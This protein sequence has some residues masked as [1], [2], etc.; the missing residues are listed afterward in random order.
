MA[1]EPREGGGGGNRGRDRDRNNNNS[2]RDEGGADV[3]LAIPVKA[4]AA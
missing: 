4:L 3:C 2:N 1:R